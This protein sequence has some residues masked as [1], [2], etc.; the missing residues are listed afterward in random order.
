MTLMK[1]MVGKLVKPI[2]SPFVQIAAI[3]RLIGFRNRSLNRLAQIGKDLLI[4]GRSSE[5][6]F[7]DLGEKLQSFS[8]RSAEIAK[9]CSAIA[10][11][12]TGLE[13]SG[14]IDLSRDISAHAR[15]IEDR[16]GKATEVIGDIL[17]SIST[18]QHH[19]H[20]FRNIIMSL[21]VLCI[22]IKIESARVG[23]EESGFGIL[24]ENVAKMIFEVESHQGQL[25]VLSESLR[26][27]LVQTVAHVSS[28]DKTRN[29]QAR[30]I[31]EHTLSN[32]QALTEKHEQSSK[33]ATEIKARYEGIAQSVSGIV[34]SMQIHDI[35]RQRMEHSATSLLGLTGKRNQEAEE[36]IEAEAGKNFLARLRERVWPTSKS[37]LLMSGRICML[38]KEQ[39]RGASEQLVE[40]VET[41]IENMKNIAS[42]ISEVVEHSKALAGDTK[43]VGETFLAG[44]ENS[45]LSTE[46]AFSGYAQA[47][48][49][50]ATAIASVGSALNDMRSFAAEIQGIG[51]K[52]KLIGLNAVVKAAHMKE[53]GTALGVLAEAMHHLSK[54]SVQ[55]IESVY[56]SL[57]GIAATAAK[58]TIEAQGAQAE[59]AS[60][61]DSMT[62][63]LK[64][65]VSGLRKAGETAFSML[66][67]ANS[68]G[69]ALSSEM[70]L[71]AAGI[72]VHRQIAEA[73]HSKIIELEEIAER[74]P[75][76]LSEQAAS[77]TGDY[78]KSLEGSY[79][80]QA[81][82]QVH[83]ALMSDTPRDDHHGTKKS[84]QVSHF[85]CDDHGSC[86]PAI[87]DVELQTIVSGP[88]GEG[89]F[90]EEGSEFGDN[91]ELF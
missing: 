21:R 50:L 56:E 55:C 16:S 59:S 7:L 33:T 30:I 79:T 27:F 6:E 31:L 90:E 48:D 29:E 2:A 42:L 57:S 61:V 70:R 72:D 26:Q 43:G 9:T 41:I 65:R 17:E 20:G 68:G 4:A 51:S 54:E 88:P 34:S 81:Q 46:S 74:F 14:T 71:T 28:L 66:E 82:R 22:S 49:E 39:L 64:A 11:Q 19:L 63:E 38:Q 69:Q 1:K 86:P 85:I 5:A 80:M 77:G 37:P 45:V 67:G 53:E 60:D 12:F 44:I 40:A 3:C 87:P 8:Y 58:I 47:K 76:D 36:A 78:L 62:N 24:G 23:D 73:I 18:L 10:D 75:M 84:E 13:I 52:M 35:T 15:Q 32:L 83:Q 25:M 89:K 91:V